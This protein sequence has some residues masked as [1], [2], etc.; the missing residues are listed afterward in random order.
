MIKTHKR[1]WIAWVICLAAV[2]S[3][4]PAGGLSRTAHMAAAEPDDSLYGATQK[5]AFDAM[6]ITEAWDVTGGS[7]D[8]VVAVLDTGV[9]QDHPELDGKV[10]SGGYNFI[11]DTSDTSDDNGHGTKIAGIIAAI[12]NNDEGIAGA[13]QNCRILP[14]KVLD[15]KGNGPVS[16][17][18]KGIR[19]AVDHGAN[20][21]NL[22][23]TCD[24]Y[25]QALQDA[26]DYAYSKNILVI[27]A[28]GNTGGAVLYPA[29]C[30]HAAAVGAVTNA[31]KLAAYSNY[32]R[33]QAL[34][35]TGSGIFSI[36]PD[37]GYAISSGTSYAVPFV[38]S[39]AALL[40]SVNEAYTPDELIS[41]MQETASDLG[42]AGWD[43]HYGYGCV[44]F[45]AAL[46]YAE[47]ELSSGD[48]NM[49]IVTNAA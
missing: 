40:L 45:S 22:S 20:I 24:G 28:S 37:G 32:G 3:I 9:A 31:G 29:A 25:Y 8:I 13:T 42:D 6:F 43:T 38:S 35:A 36:T 39:L 41:I 11:S 47:A 18:A 4:C 14:V 5:K 26:I 23:L 27:A 48:T 7:E 2:L 30:E 15:A 44:D 46:S 17:I 12:G 10:A 49:E 19:Y 16:T 1:K 33:G 21:I 34:V